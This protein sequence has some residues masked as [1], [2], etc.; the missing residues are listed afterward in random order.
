MGKPCIENLEKRALLGEINSSSLRKL[1][2]IRL[3]HEIQQNIE[4]TVLSG[5]LNIINKKKKFTAKW[6]LKEKRE[7]ERK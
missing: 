7:R 4:Y 2:Q 1:Y 5:N 3:T 6:E